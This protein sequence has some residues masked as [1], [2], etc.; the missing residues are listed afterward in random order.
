MAEELKRF[1]YEL[2]EDKDNVFKLKK[3]D[4]LS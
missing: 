4:K 2:K 3:V 1:E